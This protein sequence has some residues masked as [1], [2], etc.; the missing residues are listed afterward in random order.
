MSILDSRYALGKELVPNTI[1][2]LDI[3]ILDCY[4]MLLEHQ[5]DVR[6]FTV[7]DRSCIVGTM[8]PQNTRNS[9]DKTG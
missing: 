1:C 9:L 6:K 3:W 2:C 4:T 7:L 8:T 5:M